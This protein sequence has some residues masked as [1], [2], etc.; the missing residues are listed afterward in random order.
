MNRTKLS[1]RLHPNVDNLSTSVN[2]PSALH[3]TWILQWCFMFVICLSTVNNELYK[4][5]AQLTS[6][7]FLAVVKLTNCREDND[8]CDAR[9]YKHKHREEHKPFTHCD[10]NEE[11]K[12]MSNIVARS[13]ILSHVAKSKGISVIPVQS[14]GNL[15]SSM[16]VY[17]IG[18]ERVREGV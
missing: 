12:I 18:G 7:V 1:L 9:T 10:N 2:T 3:S 8:K 4:Q 5:A 17:D 14:S 11:Q 15:K 13:W 6:P 16:T